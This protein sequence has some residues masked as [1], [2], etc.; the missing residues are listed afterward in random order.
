MIPQSNAVRNARI[1]SRARREDR[2]HSAQRPR[3]ASP[4]PDPASRCAARPTRPSSAP[5]G[6][7]P[8]VEELVAEAVCTARFPLPT[9]PDANGDAPAAAFLLASARSGE[10]VRPAALLPTHVHGE[11]RVML[12]PG[13]HRRRYCCSSIGAR[14]WPPTRA[15]EVRRT[16]PPA[17]HAEGAALASNDPVFECIRACTQVEIRKLTHFS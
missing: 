17:P 14:R 16:D 3:N 13:A 5:A 4:L 6:P 10:H 9:K 15:L 1:E 11:R 2:N 8:A 7:P 12:K